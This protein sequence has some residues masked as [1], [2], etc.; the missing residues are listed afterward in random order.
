MAVSDANSV[1]FTY[2]LDQHTNTWINNGKHSLPSKWSSQ[3][4]IRDDLMVATVDNNP[5]MCGIVYKLSKST[6]NNNN[7]NNNNNVFWKEFARLT[8]KGDQGDPSIFQQN[9]AVSIEGSIIYTG[10]F[11]DFGEGVGK[12]FLHELP[13]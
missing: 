9:V 5:D 6:N 4:S 2:I 11:D 3:V 12:V 10:R 13:N 1:V 7:N 8:T